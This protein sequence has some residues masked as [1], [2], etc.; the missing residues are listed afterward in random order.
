LSVILSILAVQSLRVGRAG[1][2]N[3]ER[4]VFRLEIYNLRR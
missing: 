2:S 4:E 1:P 3:L